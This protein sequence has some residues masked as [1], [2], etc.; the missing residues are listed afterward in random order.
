MRRNLS[1][2]EKVGLLRFRDIQVLLKIMKQ[3]LLTVLDKH[4]TMKSQEEAGVQQQAFPISPLDD[5]K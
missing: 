5:G 4:Q 2:T 3:Q 1:A